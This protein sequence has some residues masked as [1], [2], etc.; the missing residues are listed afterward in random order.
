MPM[1]ELYTL[2]R[3]CSTPP[4]NVVNVSCT[5]QKQISLIKYIWRT[6][7]RSENKSKDEAPFLNR[8]FTFVRRNNGSCFV[9]GTSSAQYTIVVNFCS[10]IP[11]NHLTSNTHCK[12]NCMFRLKAVSA[13]RSLTTMNSAIFSFLVPLPTPKV[14][15]FRSPHLLRQ[16]TCAVSIS[17]NALNWAKYLRFPKRMLMRMATA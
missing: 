15:L 13:E 12:Y 16:R 7:F 8:S 4:K 14:L 5:V 10:N 2:Y 3:R 17:T 1:S 11:A 9:R 6:A